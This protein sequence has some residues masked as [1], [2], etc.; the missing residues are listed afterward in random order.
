MCHSVA[1]SCLAHGRDFYLRQSY[2]DD[3]ER[4][5]LRQEPERR[6]RLLFGAG[7][8]LCPIFD[9]V[10]HRDFD[11]YAQQMSETRRSYAGIATEPAL[12]MEFGRG[13]EEGISAGSFDSLEAANGTRLWKIL[14]RGE[15]SYEGRF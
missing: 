2:R 10:K 7:L 8:I 6:V 9:P 12:K 11:E 1:A 4:V 13:V 5:V 3:F 14:Q 15:G